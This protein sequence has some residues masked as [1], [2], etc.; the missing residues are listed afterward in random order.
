MQRAEYG[1]NCDPKGERRFWEQKNRAF[2][3]NEENGIHQEQDARQVRERFRRY[4]TDAASGNNTEK[5]LALEGA[6]RDLEFFII[7]M[8]NRKFRT[9]TAKDPEFYEDLLQAGRLG[10]ILSL[11]KYDPDKSM[12]TTYFFPAIMHEMTALTNGMKHD[13]KSR[14]VAL[15]RKMLEVNKKFEEYDRT[16]S[17]HDYAYNLG[18][19]FHCITDALA[20]IKASEA[21]ISMDDPD[22]AS[23]MDVPDDTSGPEE[24]AA[25]EFRFTRLLQIAREIEPDEA[26]VCCFLEASEGTE[27]NAW[28]A[29]K[30]DRSPSEIAEGILSLKNA[31][32][33]HE[34][35]RDLYPECFRGKG[36]IRIPNRTS[37]EKADLCH[38]Y[39]AVY[40]GRTDSI[41]YE[42]SRNRLS[43][44]DIGFV[45]RYACEYYLH[46][47]PEETIQKLSR[48]VL[49]TMK[50]DNLVE[51]MKLPPEISPPE[52]KMYLYCLMYPEYFRKYP[53]ESFV[54]ALYQSAISGHGKKLP[55]CFLSGSCGAE[56][57]AR[58][59]L[60]YALQT[61]G[62]C[63]TA[64][65]C[66]RLMSA[67]GAVS[68]LREAKLYQVM[69]R[70]YETPAAYVN[71]ALAMVGMLDLEELCTVFH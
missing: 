47:G 29:E 46:W 40:S 27:E 35:I 33:C 3:L 25:S 16:P 15:K 23:S 10:V 61:S 54:T 55:R 56:Q 59:C 60:M 9:Y 45:C 26:I 63:H 8:I 13:A 49:Q 17:L 62:G 71:D 31:L 6:C 53:K 43:D 38:L 69:K 20:Q 4:A 7:S 5:K 12:P 28:L 14:T 22:A 66:I 34:G 11:P 42:V 57:N 58:I 2:L 48:M 64:G 44:G 18:K 65:D 51:A 37:M 68:F 32:R 50:L 36:E 30:Y 67:R 39:D 52:K 24:T 19:S 41:L 70:R 21:R 1:Y